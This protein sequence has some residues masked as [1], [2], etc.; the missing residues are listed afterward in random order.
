M[1]K[2]LSS[3]DSNYSIKT[4]IYLLLSLNV[5]KLVVVYVVIPWSVNVGLAPNS[6]NQFFDQYAMIA[7]NLINENGYRLNA[8]F[9]PTME[10]NPGY[11]FLLYFLMSLFGNNLLMVQLVNLSLTFATSVLAFFLCKKITKNISCAYITALLV[12]LHPSI[13]FLETR[14]GVEILFMMLLTGTVA[15]LYKSIESDQIKDYFLAGLV[16][17]L[18]LLVRTSALP[19]VLFLFIYLLYINRHKSRVSLAAARTLIFSVG[20][21]LVLSPWMIR[22]YQIGNIP[23]FSENMLGM[24]F[25]LGY[26]ATSTMDQDIEYQFRILNGMEEQSKIALDYGLQFKNPDN[27]I[28][29][30][31]YTTEDEITYNKILF[32]HTF[33]NYLEKPF[34]FI[35]HCMFNVIRFWFQGATIKVTVINAL[36]TVPILAIALYGTFVSINNRYR[37]LP[38]W[39]GVF[40]VYIVHIPLI[41]QIR[42][43]VPLVPFLA[44]LFSIG[45]IRL[46]EMYT[47]KHK[48]LS[49]LFDK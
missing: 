18:C 37:I 46:V 44:I 24:S 38:L 23:T 34:L 47:L 14:G 33:N 28:W 27:S 16:F 25:F 6:A 1:L 29:D 35:K 31:F 49:N 22:N 2:A 11:V 30:L 42:F 39:M 26:Y 8:D 12:S 20:F 48:L 32:L 41:A 40:S 21:L 5:I 10:R 15:L 9:A 3:S 13:M 17:G 43:F 7:V 4:L 45:F 36:T 19:L